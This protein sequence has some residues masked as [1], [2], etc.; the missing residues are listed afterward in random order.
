MMAISSVA[1][2]I[3]SAH[4]LGGCDGQARADQGAGG[5][6][7]QQDNQQRI[8]RSIHSVHE[9]KKQNRGNAQQHG[10]AVA[11]QDSRAGS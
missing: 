3:S 9:N 11:L 5:G 1:R 8:H 4:D 6:N 2:L 10:R 7:Q